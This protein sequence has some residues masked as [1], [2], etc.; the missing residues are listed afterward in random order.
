MTERIETFGKKVEGEAWENLGDIANIAEVISPIIALPD[1]HQKASLEAPTSIAVA[2]EG[3]LIPA[4]TTPTLGCSIGSIITDLQASE[5]SEE[6]YKKFHSALM[7]EES[8]YDFTE[9][10][11]IQ[12]A[13]EGARAVEQK[14]NL[15]LDTHEHMENGGKAESTLPIDITNIPPVA[16]KEG[17]GRVGV[18]LHGNHFLELQEVSEVVDESLAKSWGLEKGKILVSYHGG[19]GSLS[20]YIGRYYSQRKKFPFKDTLK[21]LPKKVAFHLLSP[22]ANFERISYFVPGWQLAYMNSDEGR[23]LTSMF[24]AGLNFGYATRAAMIRRIAD[25]L[26]TAAGRKV[27]LKLLWDASHTTIGEELI[28]GKNVWVHRNGAVRVYKDKPLLV[29]GAHN[30]HSLIAVGRPGA[31]KYLNS[32]DHGSGVTTKKF[33]AAGKLHE[34]GGEATTYKK[35][36]ET[37]HKLMSRD[38]LEFV[39]EPLA[40]RGILD[41]VAYTLPL[42]TFR[43]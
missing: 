4:L 18:S 3:V 38:G 6:F 13:L 26:E 17:R 36:G 7:K 9:E 24:A 37:K 29:S 8:K 2:T 1:V 22:G 28:D 43:D 25:C 11:F 30:T 5:L 32:A 40:E 42:A 27:S 33:A 14:Y 31:E 15:P 10:E 34:I 12:A 23:R 16:I 35:S 19:E 21:N 39:V 20:Y 41:R